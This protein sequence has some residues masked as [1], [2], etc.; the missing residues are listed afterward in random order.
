MWPISMGQDTTLVDR[1]QQF[2][3]TET[4]ASVYLAVVERGEATPSTIASA[5]GVS[6]SYVY[7]LCTQLEQHGVVSVE[8]HHSPTRVRAAPPSEALQARLE[9]M[10]ETM[11]EV[12]DR[13]ERP[14][15][16][17]EALE[18]VRSRATLHKRFR[19][20]IESATEEVFA[21]VP[22][23][24]VPEIADALEDA[25]ERDVFVLLA[26]AGST[27][28]FQNET[29]SNVATVVRSWVRGMTVCLTSDRSRG[30]ISPAEM[31]DWKHGD[32]EAIHFENRTVSLSVESAFLGSMWPASEE[33]LLRRPTP[34]PESYDSF[35]RAVY[36]ATL[37]HRTGRNVAVTFRARP[38][39]TTET[40]TERTGTLAGTRQGLVEER[41]VEFGMENSIL[42][43]TD[44][45]EVSVG[46]IGA[47]LEDYKA[48]H[49]SL[50]PL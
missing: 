22:A 33:L 35:R 10:S 8:D 32:A 30:I 26:I 3:F 19:Q 25:V 42:V 5:A 18:V 1:L 49:V 36:D 50:E 21:T 20:A 14:S 41:D 17:F 23:E 45:G 12:A 48:E 4:E 37:H 13:Y 47:F 15:K 31:L 38:V 39:N 44:A 28:A 7:Q 24:M 43:E 16:D 11:E 9:T 34:L 46:D 2:G 27:D 6:S 29:L 40:P